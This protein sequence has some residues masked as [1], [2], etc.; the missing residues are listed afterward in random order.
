MVDAREN[1]YPR[2]GLRLEQKDLLNEPQRFLMCPSRVPI[3]H[4]FSARQRNNL[5]GA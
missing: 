1:N 4:P 3:A 2:G 5:R